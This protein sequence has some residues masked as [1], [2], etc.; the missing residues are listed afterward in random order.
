ME[1][2]AGHLVRHP[3]AWAIVVL[4]LSALAVLGAAR[5]EIDDVPRSIFRTEDEHFERLERLFADFGSD[6]N[7]C[8]IVLRTADFF[9]PAA[10]SCVRELDA[11]LGALEGVAGSFGLP[12][13]FTL[14]GGLPRPL[15]PAEGA[16]AEAFESARAA[17]REHPFVQDQL[18]SPDGGTLLHVARLAGESLSVSSMRPV[19]DR[20]RAVLAE[21]GGRAGV[22]MDLTGIP[23][24][25]VE[26]FESLAREQVL[27]PIAGGV[28]GVLAGLAVLRRWRPVLATSAAALTSALWALGWMGWV[29]EPV[30]LLSSSLPLLIM[31]IALT[32]GV[33][34]ALD[35]QRERGAGTA[36]REAARRAVAHLG[37]ACLLTSLTTAV[38]FGSLAVSRVRIIHRFG[39]VFAGAVLLAFLAVIVIVPLLSSR[40]AAGRAGST[41]VAP[42]PRARRVAE[43]FI[44]AVLR[45]AHAVSAVGIATTA[46]LSYAATLLVPDNR[47]T[48]ATPD[49]RQAATRALQHCETVF[50]GVLETSV[51]LEWPG[52]ITDPASAGAAIADAQAVLEAHSFTSGVRSVLDA[53]A[54]LPGARWEGLDLL[55]GELVRRYWRPDLARARI[56]ARVPDA[57]AALAD[58]AYAEIQEGLAAVERRHPEC[59]VHLTGTGWVARRNV[60]LI[61]A[62]FARGLG[63]AGILIFGFLALAFRSV[64]IG[65]LS[66]VP[67]ALPLAVCAS[68]L[69]FLGMN[70]QVASAIAFSLC[71]G[72]AVDDTIHF[73]NRY[74]LELTRTADEREAVVQAFLSVGSALAATTAILLAGLAVLFLSD[75]PTTRLFAGLACAGLGAALLGDLVLLPA[76]LVAFRRPSRP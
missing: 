50:G 27:F 13:V 12:D 57:G 38:G 34:L 30:Q 35:V 49:G 17:A 75:I 31:V 51:L 15:L 70:L 56:V 28:L 55:P 53:L 64:R 74:R 1:R 22:R 16:A 32:D 4:A 44:R 65:A 26:I 42:P 47:L 33:H 11:R 48:E 10:A 19:L 7:D 3:R 76:M 59:R 20:I 60:N 5:L 73:L 40:G 18:L 58:T 61:I 67:N 62:D 14:Q 37:V 36:P 25:R 21:L 46:L 29:G 69:V 41:P 52:G 2:F 43:A 6:D 8:L 9:A 66:I 63:L 23:P 68:S 39:L 71:L 54:L 72:I 24:I 45:R